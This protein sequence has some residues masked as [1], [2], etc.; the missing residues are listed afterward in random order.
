MTENMT[1]EAIKSWVQILILLI[2][3]YGIWTSCIPLEPGFLLI[4]TPVG[5]YYY[6][7]HVLDEDNKTGKTL[8]VSE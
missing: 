8:L 7:L 5:G 1:Y 6:F 4:I 2:I 3:S